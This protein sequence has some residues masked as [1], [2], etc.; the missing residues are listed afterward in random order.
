V[1]YF[2]DQNKLF[3]LNEDC[4]ALTVP[5]PQCYWDDII[6][7]FG[8]LSGPAYKRSRLKSPEDITTD[9]PQ[10]YSVSTMEGYRSAIISLYKNSRPIITPE[11]GLTKSL[12]QYIVRT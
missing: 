8:Y 11:D 5:I 6:D 7:F 3:L 2:K 9:M 1:E 12:S 4:T 10:P